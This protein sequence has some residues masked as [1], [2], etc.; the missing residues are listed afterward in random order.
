[1]PGISEDDGGS[2][3]SEDMDE[4]NKEVF[5]EIQNYQAELV[6][7]H[8][9]YNPQTTKLVSKEFIME[10]FDRVRIY[11]RSSVLLWY[12][13]FGVADLLT[14]LCV[15]PDADDP[16]ALRLQWEYLQCVDWNPDL[17]KLLVD[18]QNR[19]PTYNRYVDRE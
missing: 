17:Y 15:Q 2:V 16:A 7:W 10:A 8:K 19:S 13:F 4:C 18:L 3:A 11:P 12:I 5:E 6:L 9:K 1:L 14:C